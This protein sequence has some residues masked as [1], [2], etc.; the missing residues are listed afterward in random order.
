M[1]NHGR[2]FRLRLYMWAILPPMVHVKNI[3]D[4]TYHARLQKAKV[5]PKVFCIAAPSKR[6]FNQTQTD[7][8]STA[9]NGPSI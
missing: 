4:I 6:R 7:G 1:A 2:S 8:E 3:T 5:T 9:C